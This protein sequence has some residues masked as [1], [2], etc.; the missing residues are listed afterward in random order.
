MR[1]VSFLSLVT[2]KR[3]P[4]WLRTLDRIARLTERFA[5][6][7]AAVRDESAMAWIPASDRGRLTS[8]IFDRQPTYSPGGNIFRRGLF[9]WE[10]ELLEPP[11]PQSGRILVG[12]A[13]GGREA[14]ALLARGYRVV[15]FDP[16][17]ELVR[18]GAPAVAEAGGALLCASYDDV[19]RAARGEGTPLDGVFGEQFD[20]VLLGWGSVSLIVSDEERRA[21]L[22]ALRMLMPRAPVV[23]SFDEP[24][25]SEIPGSRVGRARAAIRRLNARMG[26]P[27][28]TG[29]RMRYAAWAGIL[30]ESSLEEVGAIARA[31]GYTVAKQRSGQGRM[32]LMPAIDA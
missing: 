31:A 14:V 19:V 1:P 27:G 4:W 7:V 22:R 2:L 28:Y 21:L 23:L 5:R 26:A 8:L 24:V 11:F 10:E 12:G 18:A 20:G 30:R 13:G 15:A 9:P 17:P 25:D 16:S 32:L 29:E 3:I 6:L